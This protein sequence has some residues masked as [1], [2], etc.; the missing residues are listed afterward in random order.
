LKDE[1]IR[2]AGDRWRGFK[3]QLTTKYITRPKPNVRPPF[4]KYDYI[5]EAIWKEF[6]KSRDTPEFKVSRNMEIVFVHN[7]FIMFSK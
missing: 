1:W 5:T 4:L 7:I 2:Y 3:T 6:V